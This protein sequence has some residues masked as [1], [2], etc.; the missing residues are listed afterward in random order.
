MP[1]LEV[2]LA[3]GDTAFAREG[4]DLGPEGVDALFCTFCGGDTEEG[5]LGGSD[6]AGRR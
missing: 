4:E 2:A 1:R 3:C 5:S 6:T